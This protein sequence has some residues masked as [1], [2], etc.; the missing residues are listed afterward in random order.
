MKTQINSVI[1]NM[2]NWGLL[3]DDRM[4]VIFTTN[5]AISTYHD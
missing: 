3:G 1:Y 4:L 2:L 5:Y